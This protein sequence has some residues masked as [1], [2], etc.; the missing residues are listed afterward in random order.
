MP[1]QGGDLAVL[2]GLDEHCTQSQDWALDCENIDI[3]KGYLLTGRHVLTCSVLSGR[4]SI[5]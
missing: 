4:D 1:R 2:S 5:S 3:V